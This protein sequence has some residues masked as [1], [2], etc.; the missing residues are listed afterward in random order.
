[1]KQKPAKR[2]ARAWAI[3]IPAGILLLLLLAA[4]LIGNGGASA[5]RDDVDAI[6]AAPRSEELGELLLPHDASSVPSLIE[7]IRGNAD[8]LASSPDAALNGNLPKRWTIEGGQRMLVK[9][10]RSSGR[11]Q[12]PFNE[13]I[14]SVLCSR[15]LDEGDYVAYELEDGG[16][17]KWTSRC[18]PMTDQ[19]TEFVPAWALLC[20]SKRPSDLGLHDFYVS[21]CAAHHSVISIIQTHDEIMTAG[22]LCHGLHFIIGGL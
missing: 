18:K 6:L 13:K 12:E 7:K 22:C 2:G 15:L 4:F 14:A 3:A 16:F 5:F 1:M 21:A 8:L 19:V 11:F 10:G 17:M 20:S 9:S